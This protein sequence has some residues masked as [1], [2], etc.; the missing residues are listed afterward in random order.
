ME[1]DFAERATEQNTTLDLDDIANLGIAVF[2]VECEDQNGRFVDAP[3]VNVAS[4]AMFD[5]NDEEVVAELGKSRGHEGQ[6][7][8][9][10]H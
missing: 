9:A 5:G 7:S 3:S 6:P 10:A 1:L 8:L 4:A 2:S